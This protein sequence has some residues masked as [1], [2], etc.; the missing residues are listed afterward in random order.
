MALTSPRF[1]ASR[2]LRMVAANQATLSKGARG[3][4]VHLVQQALLD[5]G[6]RLPRSTGSAAYSPDGVFGDE[7]LAKLK[8]F[9]ARNGLKDDGVL[10]HRTLQAL[11]RRLPGYQHH[12]RLHYRSIALPKVSFERSLLDAQVIFGQYGIKV[13][14]GSGES[15]LLTPA[16]M[17]LFDRIDNDCEWTLSTGEYNELH[18]LG[19]RAPDNEILVYQVKALKAGLLGCGGHAVNRPAVTVAAH[20]SRWDTAHEVGH[21]LL[22]SGFSPVH[23]NDR[24]NLMHPTA[25][26]YSTIPVLT[27]KQVQQMRR[28]VC[29][30]GP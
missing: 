10:G 5:L 14:Y 16:Q 1:I 11:A 22:G 4:S 28:S 19:T 17:R 3:R 26:T 15:M 7:T 8:E 29:C 21:V 24:R 2:H 18:S 25:A 20:A 9:Q 12:V 6:Y 27:D 13:D 23:V 30:K